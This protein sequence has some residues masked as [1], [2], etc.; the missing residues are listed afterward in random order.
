MKIEKKNGQIMVWCDKN[1]R[2]INKAKSI[3]GH[4]WEY[5]R[6]AFPEENEALVRKALLE[7][8]A[9]D[10]LKHETI[11]FDIDLG[12]YMG[13]FDRELRIG[14]VLIAK[15]PGRDKLVNMAKNALIV[16]GGFYATG[17]TQSG[18]V[19][20]YTPGTVIRIRNFPLEL[21]YKIPNYNG[22]HVVKNDGFY[23]EEKKKKKK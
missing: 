9:E 17:G 2:F 7:T 13:D 21:Y 18:P 19:V 12:K 3:Q 5:G 15:R 14:D 11:T 22:I 23:C 4:E 1:T 20:T 16:K 8:F 10:G 6:W